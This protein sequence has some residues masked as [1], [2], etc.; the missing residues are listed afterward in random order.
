VVVPMMVVLTKAVA[1]VQVA[2]EQAQHQLQVA[3]LIQSLL[4][5]VEQVAAGSSWSGSDSSGQLRQ[6][7]QQVG[8]MVLIKRN[9]NA[10]DGGS[11]G[12]GARLWR[13]NRRCR[14]TW[15]G[16]PGGTLPGN[17]AGDNTGQ[18]WRWWCW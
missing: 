13:L 16:I 8:G 3:Q 17:I 5:Q 4:E 1:V 2:L 11:G 9:V 7:P 18:C 6:L 14:C 15:T 10:A 12:G